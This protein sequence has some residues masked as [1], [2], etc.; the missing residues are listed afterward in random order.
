MYGKR[1]TAARRRVPRQVP[2]PLGD[3]AWLLY[4]GCALPTAGQPSRTVRGKRSLL[5]T[6]IQARLRLILFTESASDMR[7]VTFSA[8][9]LP[10]RCVYDT[11]IYH[12]LSPT[13]RREALERFDSDT[14]IYD[15]IIGRDAKTF[16]IL[17]PR[18]HA[19]HSQYL[20]DCLVEQGFTIRLLLP[21]IKSHIIVCD[22]PTARQT[23]EVGNIIYSLDLQNRLV[24]YLADRRPRRISYTL[25]KD[26]H[27]RHI[28]DWIDFQFTSY[29]A[30]AVILFDNRSSTSY[31][32][33]ALCKTFAHL[34]DSL[35]LDLVPFKYGPAGTTSDGHLLKTYKDLMLQASMF[36]YIKSCI[37]LSGIEESL[38]LNTD[39]D[40]LI[41]CREGVSPF[42]ILPQDKL[43]LLFRGY[44][45]YP[46]ASKT[47]TSFASHADHIVLDIAS[48]I[49]ID[50][51][52]LMRVNGDTFP[53]WQNAHLI[54]RLPDNGRP[55]SVIEEP[56]AKAIFLHH[57]AVTNRWRGTR[58]TPRHNGVILSSRSFQDIS[59][60]V[61]A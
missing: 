33:K 30:D 56:D 48:R 43:A 45:C 9:G 5:D 29:A 25:Q 40:E 16:I 55:G 15:I 36:E 27:L 20:Q 47:N 49:D 14:F 53:C 54:T 10:N 17:S 59:S 2:C 13:A 52:W 60:A 21:K 44:W 22:N 8:C 46:P 32:Y 34:G 6:T 11:S 57:Y 50:R 23:L 41:F 37:L 19:L 18:L 35:F 24:A 28:K 61:N 38:L 51:K 7:P 4:A 3:R 26:E 12:Q 39:I 31:E 1:G 42:S 58:L